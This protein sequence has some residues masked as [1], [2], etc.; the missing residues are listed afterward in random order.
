MSKYYVTCTWEEVPHLSEK[1]KQEI[2]K[3]IPP[4]QRDARTKG[5]PSLGAGAIYPV[6]ETEVTCDP[7]VLPTYWRRGY[8]FDVGWNKTAAIWGALDDQSDILYLYSEHY[9]GLAEPSVHAEAIR[10]RGESLPGVIDPA[11]RGRAQKDGEQLFENYKQLGLIL[12][13]AKNGV[14]SGIFDV[15]QRLSTGRLKIFSTLQNT[16]AEYRIYRRD[17]NGKIVKESDHLMDC[18]R[19]LVVSGIP[20]LDFPPEY[21]ASVTHRPQHLSHYNPLGR[22]HVRQDVTVASTHLY[23][24]NALKRD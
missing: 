10:S 8:G 16:L 4:H 20:I 17:D 18:M 3:S 2:Y 6:P 23:E 11:S 22:E 1:E 13:P 19:Y 5:I 15:Y 24:Y 12:S 21:L 7:F 9:R 14:E